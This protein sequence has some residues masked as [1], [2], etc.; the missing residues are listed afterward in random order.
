M[1]ASSNPKLSIE[2]L[3]A[4]ET[5]PPQSFPGAEYRFDPDAWHIMQERDNALIEQEILHGAGSSK[6]VYSY[7]NGTD[8]VSGVSVIG[9]RHLAATYG[10]IKHSL[11]S[12]ITKTGAQMLCMTYPRVSIPMSMHCIL[13]PELMKEDDFYTVVIEINDLKTG[14]VIQVET[15]ETRIGLKKGGKET[16]DKIHYKAIAQS[17]A[18]RNGVLDILPQDVTIE[19]KY[20]MLS[21]GKDDVITRDVLGEKRAGVLRYAARVGLEIDRTAVENLLMP[22]IAGLSDAAAHE[23]FEGFRASAAALRILASNQAASRAAWAGAWP[24]Q[25][26]QPA[27]QQGPKA[28]PKSRAQ[29]TAAAPQEQA[30]PRE[31]KAQ[32]KPP[33]RLLRL[34]SA[35]GEVVLDN[36]M[37]L[38]DWAKEFVDHLKDVP[39]DMLLAYEE[40]NADII[41]EVLADPSVRD[42]LVEV[43]FGGNGPAAAASNKPDEIDEEALVVHK[44]AGRVSNAQIIDL[45]SQALDAVD[46]PTTMAAWKRVNFENLNNFHA[47][48]KM[49]IYKHYGLRCRA[50]GMELPK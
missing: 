48:I 43:G 14:N 19:W 9:A 42:I 17:K 30:A 40:H 27:P 6:F 34:I 15:S 21:L 28:A 22:Q 20:K 4:T 39:G 23:Q 12:S 38:S 35:D 1:N 44:P 50:L 2:S 11:I 13:I 47:L 25:Q 36:A 7:H 32:K 29:P 41:E 3:T 33:L 8:M 24:S 45:W 5:R 16:Y 49:P 31:T 46:N 37:N 26:E 18:F 10:G